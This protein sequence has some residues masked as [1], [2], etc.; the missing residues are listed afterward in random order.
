MAGSQASSER[1]VRNGRPG[2]E[3]DLRRCAAGEGIE[4]LQE[5]WVLHIVHALLDGPKGFNE[6]GRIV[7]GCNPTTLTQRL[8]RLEELGV[9][10]KEPGRAG[11][12]CSYSLT[13]AG[14][15]LERVIAAIRSWAA[16]H[17]RNGSHVR[18]A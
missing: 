18:D 10:H 3:R 2:A 14:L 11:G 12:R 7:G 15:G 1:P 8:S 13:E 16:A 5:K 9:L 6:L 4:V 17:L